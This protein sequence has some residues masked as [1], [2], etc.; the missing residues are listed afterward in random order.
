MPEVAPNPPVQGDKVHTRR[1][2]TGEYSGKRHPIE[3]VISYNEDMFFWDVRD[4]RGMVYEVF[5]D[6]HDKEWKER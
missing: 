5:W 6:T 3:E 1:F 2:T 4:N